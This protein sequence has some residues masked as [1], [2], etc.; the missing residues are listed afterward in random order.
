M[1]SHDPQS[2]PSEIKG[3]AKGLLMFWLPDETLFSLCSRYHRLS[4]DWQAHQTNIVLFGA[5]HG[6]H[7]HDFPDCLDAFVQRTQGSL[8]SAQELIQDRTLLPFYLPFRG[9]GLA[10][11]CTQSMRDQG[12]GSL[13]FRLGLLTS[14]FRAHHP[15]KACIHCMQED[16]EQGHAPYW[17]RSHQF[18]GVWVCTRHQEP[19][20][21]SSSKATGVG[22]F[23]WHLPDEMEPP[24]ELGAG[25]ARACEPPILAQL[26]R[27]ADACASLGRTPI[28]VQFDPEMLVATFSQRLLELE[29]ISQTGR[30]Y[31][32]RAAKSL[33]DYSK[34]FSAVAELAPLAVSEASAASQLILTRDPARALT[35]PLRHVWLILW[36][37]DDWKSFNAA[38]LASVDG[39]AEAAVKES[40]KE[41]ND[42]S[43]ASDEKRQELVRLLSS[44]SSVLH[45]AST[46]GIATATAMAWAAQAG[47]ETRR[48]PKKLKATVRDAI[49][50]KLRLGSDKQEVAN[51]Y[52]VSVQ[53][54][55]TT[56]RTE[57]G[58]HDAWK[59]ARY[60]NA[61]DKHRQAWEAT[62]KTH[63]GA[64]LIVVRHL[65]AATYAWLYR[66][67]RTWL[68][69]RV[70]KL[71]K[72]HGGNN[73]NL[74]WES[75][76][77]ALCAAVER[78]C[79]ELSRTSPKEHRA[80]WE[81]YQRVP[82]LKAKLTRL[83]RLPLT[84][85]AVKRAIQGAPIRSSKDSLF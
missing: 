34:A 84:H 9:Q 57:V 30:F 64:S 15:L 85:A 54:I 75:R 18:P 4:S 29:F 38:Y 40:A 25:W 1:E 7:A 5:R 65:Q 43:A 41:T 27:F 77:V 45:A 71:P 67:D 56:L 32:E 35:H 13:K 10:E 14:R 22:R 78:A 33:A 3:L 46:L 53:T 55:T 36:L 37:F 48:R 12:I 76:D 63:P 49:L 79:E 28:G 60:Q 23:G 11:L 69:Q 66:N 61:R 44:G 82:E 52:G 39:V 51:L 31:R 26:S 6:G 20:L 73:S 21:A 58:L 19:L 68:S 81:I 80:L 2:H 50:S 16:L 74:Q 17:R 42:A 59:A 24:S 70:A 72:M 83:D 8:G 62:C 47:I